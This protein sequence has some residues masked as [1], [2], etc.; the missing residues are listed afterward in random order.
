MS[1]T[2]VS[3]ARAGV[4][5]LALLVSAPLRPAAVL[6]ADGDSTATPAVAVPVAHGRLSWTSNRLPLHVGDLVTVVVAE[7]ANATEHVS[8]TSTGNRGQQA[9]LTGHVNTGGT[10]TP[11]NYDIGLNTGLSNDSK[12]IGDAQ[13]TG[14]LTAVLTVRITA[15]ETEGIARIEGHKQ[16]TVDGR[17]QDV[18]LKGLIR[19]Q[20][21]CPGNTVPSN[22]IADAVI[23][24]KGKKIAPNTSFVG[25]LLGMVWP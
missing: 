17:T 21:I 4:L 24:Y 16:V 3:R 19:T 23:T 5:A 7:Q 25:K 13:R 6:A 12:D 9:T 2:Q 11:S 14:G 15:F 1:N 22:R 10:S 20:D 8:R 18:M